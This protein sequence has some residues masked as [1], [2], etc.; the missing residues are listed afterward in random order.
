MLPQCRNLPIRGCRPC[1]VEVGG[2]TESVTPTMK[3]RDGRV[4]VHTAQVAM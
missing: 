1:H 3:E 4:G 2:C